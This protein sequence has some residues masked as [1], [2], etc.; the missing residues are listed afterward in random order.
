MNRARNRDPHPSAGSGQAL[1]SFPHW[2]RGRRAALFAFA[3]PITIASRDSGAREITGCRAGPAQGSVKPTAGFTLLPRT[4]VV[5][6]PCHNTHDDS[7]SPILTNTLPCATGL[8]A[9]CAHYSQTSRI[10]AHR[11]IISVPPQSIPSLP[12]ALG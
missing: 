10:P 6:R 12:A 7:L 9:I 11:Q 2:A 3:A 4:T 1:R 5:I 8:L